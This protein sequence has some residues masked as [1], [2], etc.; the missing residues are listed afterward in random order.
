MTGE[1]PHPG[2]DLRR[3]PGAGAADRPGPAVPRRTAGPGIGPGPS[4]LP[5]RPPSG[6]PVTRSSSATSPSARNNTRSAHAAAT[7]S[8]VTI[9]TVAPSPSTDCRSSASTSSAVTGSSAPVGSSAQM[10]SG[11]V[12]RARASATRCCWPPDSSLGLLRARSPRPTRASASRARSRWT[13]RLPR[14]PPPA[15]RSGSFTFC[16]AVSAGSRLKDWKTKPTWVLRSL[17]S[18]RCPIP[19]SSWPPSRTLPEVGRSRPTAHWSSVLLPDPE[20]PITAVKL[21]LGSATPTPRSA[22]SAPRPA[23]IAG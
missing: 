14:G 3:G 2:G 22:C 7:G 6:P 20:G 19:V 5:C 4:E 16:S 23:H 17:V 10:I 9:S 21:P 8:W 18:E 13:R 15:S 12:T 1:R 11:S